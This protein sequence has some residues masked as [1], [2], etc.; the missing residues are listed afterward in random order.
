[1]AGRRSQS[2]ERSARFDGVAQLLY[3]V[4]ESCYFVYLHLYFFFAFIFVFVYILV[5]VF[6]SVFV[7]LHVYLYLIFSSKGSV[8]IAE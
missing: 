4:R 5:F 2:P 1:M 7:L 6:V 3:Q 8:S